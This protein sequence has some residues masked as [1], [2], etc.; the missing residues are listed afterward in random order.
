MK[1]TGGE[2]PESHKDDQLFDKITELLPIDFT[3]KTGEGYFTKDDYGI[4]KDDE[5]RIKW[6]YRNDKYITFSILK[7]SYYPKNIT[8]PISKPDKYEC[9]IFG[10]EKDVSQ[11]K[12]KNF[13]DKL[14]INYE[15][16][17]KVRRVEWNKEEEE[18]ELNII[19]QKEEDIL[20]K[21]TDKYNL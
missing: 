1:I 8:D 20:T 18:E 11:E 10:K 3:F 12:L 17:Q 6:Y 15:K 9:E 14:E 5:K 19:K 16:I 13:F 21:A 7:T 2:K 4:N